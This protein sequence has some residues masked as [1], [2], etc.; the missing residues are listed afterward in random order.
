[1][2]CRSSEPECRT[3]PIWNYY[4]T[5]LRGGHV[6]I[7]RVQDVVRVFYDLGD[8]Q[9]T[10]IDQRREAAEFGAVNALLPVTGTPVSRR[11]SRRSSLR[12]RFFHDGSRRQIVGQVCTGAFDCWSDR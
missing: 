6:G 9:F 2:G 8:C 11:H 1:M 5:H 12:R 4:L 7:G 3:T 10:D